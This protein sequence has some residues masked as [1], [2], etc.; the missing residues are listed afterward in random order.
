MPTPKTMA[1]VL[2]ANAAADP[3]GEA[4]GEIREGE[5]SWLS[6]E[7][8]HLEVD[9]WIDVLNSCEVS[10]GEPV[11]VCGANSVN[12]CLIDLA[13]ARIGAVSV[14][15]HAA[16]PPDQVHAI[17]WR[18]PARWRFVGN[19][20]QKTGVRD[21][22]PA[23]PEGVATIVHTSGTSGE[24]LGVELTHGN[25]LFNATALSQAVSSGV[26]QS[27]DDEVRLCMLPLSH[28]YAR[29]C[30]LYTWL[31][32]RSKL[33]LAESRETILRD[34][35]LARP[36]AINSVPYFY[37]KLYSSVASADATARPAMLRGLLGGRVRHCYSGGAPQSEEI[38]SAF[39]AAGLPLMSGY[40]LTEASPVVTASTISDRKAGTVGRPLPGVQ[41][42]LGDDGEVLVA[43]PGVMLGYLRSR[44]ATRSAVRDGWLH[45]GD[46]GAWTDDGFL[47]I[48][49]RKKELI[50][51]STGKKASPAAIEAKIAASPLIEQVI[52][53]GEGRPCLGAIIV[54]NPDGL[55]AE[56]RA[57]RLW[58]WTKR[59]ALNHPHIRRLYAAEIAARAGDDRIGVF[60]LVGRGFSQ[61]L[62]ELTP[63]LS[64]RR[65]TIAAHFAE[66][67]NAM[68]ANKPPSHSQPPAPSP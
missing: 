37:Q 28:L 6:W 64:L 55:R 4:L 14:P 51:L 12:W 22:G 5:L 62:D 11:L 58:V 54:P 18:L 66:E 10:P 34:C 65:E 36:T 41:V 38:E 33:V 60:T 48:T 61:A 39:E 44:E 13:L 46:L 49:G 47:T 68:Y 24:P 1:D 63:K 29:T 50:V 19:G 30:D 31:V 57:K 59:G 9:G 52:V 27:R 42:R 15:V 3:D 43:G 32:R 25:L 16:T 2:A 8:I 40:G 7:L 35:Q 21:R 56:V 20:F 53:V 67:I 45:T 17:A 26:S 23:A